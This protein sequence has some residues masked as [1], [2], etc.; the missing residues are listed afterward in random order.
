MLALESA[1]RP[2]LSPPYPL[3]VLV[4]QTQ[5]MIGYWLVQELRNAGVAQPAACVL[6]QTIVDPADPAF[7][8]PSK[9]IGPATTRMRRGRWPRAAGG[10][11]RPTG[12]AGG[13]WWPRPGRWAWWRSRPSAPLVDAGVLVVCGGGGGVPVARGDR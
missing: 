10:P 5:G 2:S 1:V 12:P 11:S 13:A 8:H 7:G 4:A 9:F 6:S 3:D